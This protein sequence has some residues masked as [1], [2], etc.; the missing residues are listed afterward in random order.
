MNWLATHTRPLCLALAVLAV[1]TTALG[2][3]VYI[4]I[5]VPILPGAATLT[6]PDMASA[7][8]DPEHFAVSVEYEYSDSPEGTVISQ[9]PLPG[10]RR[11]VSDG[12]PCRVTLVLSRGQRCKTLPN[13]V[14]LDISAAKSRLG[15]L[16]IDFTSE[17]TP[18]PLGRIMS[19]YPAAGEELDADCRVRLLVGD[20][21]VTVIN[22]CGM[23]ESAARRAI[24]AS[25]LSV[26]GSEYTRSNRPAGTVIAQ[27]VAP[28]T[29]LPWGDS[30]VLT[31]SQGH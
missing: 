8:P 2:I 31:V 6:V 17:P 28:G 25:G 22:A 26:G 19:T 7:A 20:K 12:R 24:E 3:A 13:L 30:I 16:G 27:S 29:S 18:G 11:K 14:G 23:S 9:S 15:Q 10:T 21:A 1:V 4:S 5:M